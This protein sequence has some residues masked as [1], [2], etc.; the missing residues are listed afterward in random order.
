ME[1]NVTNVFEILSVADKEL[2]HSSMIKFLI[3]SSPALNSFLL[4]AENERA[5]CDLEVS[6][7]FG[8]KKLRF[9]I[10]INRPSATEPLKEPMVVIENKFKATPTVKQLSLYDDYLNSKFSTG[11][12]MPKKVLLVFAYEQIP[13]DVDN[14]CIEFGWEKKSYFSLVNDK[15]DLFSFLDLNS[16]HF[17]YS[18]TSQQLLFSNY[19]GYLKSYKKS[20][21]KLV[22]GEDHLKVYNKV[23]NDS[24]S[25]DLWF[26]Y[27]LYLQGMLSDKLKEYDFE[28]SNDGGAHVVPSI[29][30][31]FNSH[32]FGID[33]K[34]LKLGFNY[35]REDVYRESI[36]E[37][38]KRLTDK[39]IEIKLKKL[40]GDII[41]RKL[42]SKT[43]G[44]S[45]TSVV[46]FDILAC[47]NTSEIIE[48]ASILFREFHKI[49]Q[50][51]DDENQD[52]LF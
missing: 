40:V 5:K 43:I 27:L 10:V 51:F 15:T 6:D 14:Y 25:R 30:F 20:I 39:I 21:Q 1:S 24:K 47:D 33:G 19:L 28:S 46:S 44:Q 37:Y 4:L 3:E 31:W 52:F 26:K 32:Y 35:K 22:D 41:N 2:V 18:N 42:S 50:Q 9:D 34:S 49:I 45:V 11:K 29:A 17:S 48:D 36:K 16:G 23:S 8:K 7:R 12:D 13:S 38:K